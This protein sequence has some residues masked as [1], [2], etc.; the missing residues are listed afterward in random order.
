VNRS[1]DYYDIQ[2]QSLA[3]I[4]SSIANERG[5]ETVPVNQP[6]DG[7]DNWSFAGFDVPN[8]DL[9]YDNEYE[10]EEIGGWHYAGY[11]HSP[12]DTVE[13]AKEVGG[14]LEDMVKVA[15]SAALDLPQKD[16]DTKV[17]PAKKYH[18]LFIGNHTDDLAASPSNLV[19]FSMALASKGFDIS[20][21]GKG[22]TVTEATLS[23]VDMVVVMPV[24][25][26]PNKF[27][28]DN[29]YDESWAKEEI[30]ILEKYVANGGLVMLTNSSDNDNEDIL[31]MNALAKPFG[32]TYQDN[33]ANRLLQKLLKITR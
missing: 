32:I 14:V 20:F 18:A 27:N 6:Y 24:Y 13:L 4:I 15:L 9:V 12:Y 11:A 26:F 5:V 1:Y 7:S 17:T 3:D 33:K 31:D 30:E 23:D 2:G 16:I 22:I 19:E 8:V 21:I 10:T 25:D 29:Q 28:G